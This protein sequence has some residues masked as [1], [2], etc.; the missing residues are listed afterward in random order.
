MSCVQPFFKFFHPCFMG[1]ILI[2]LFLL[3]WVPNTTWA[4]CVSI[5][6][7]MPRCEG[8]P[9]PLKAT[10]LCG[11]K[12]SQTWYTFG[13]GFFSSLSDTET[14]YYP[15]HDERVNGSF[16]VGFK[17]KFTGGAEDSLSVTGKINF[18]PTGDFT[19]FTTGCEP[20][21]TSFD[22]KFWGADSIIWDFGDG[23]IKVG[24]EKIPHTY[25]L[26]RPKPYDVY[27]RLVSIAG[28]DT[29]L[30]K[31][32]FVKVNISPNANFEMSTHQVVYPSSPVVTFQNRSDIKGL[33]RD[34]V[35]FKWYRNGILVGATKMSTISYAFTTGPNGKNEIELKVTSVNG[36]DGTYYD[37]VWVYGA[38]PSTGIT[39]PGAIGRKNSSDAIGVMREQLQKYHE[40]RI[41]VYNILGQKMLQ[42]NDAEA[43]NRLSQLP[44]GNYL[45]QL[46]LLDDEGMN[47]QQRAKILVTE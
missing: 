10:V 37:Y 39:I 16:R 11:Q 12:L 34:S 15:G 6:P 8:I 19:G 47:N 13:D 32:G 18:T 17:V 2:S 41:E 14:I 43:L 40:Y 33:P 25:F 21:F 38:G 26:A 22:G 28:C 30:A 35:T 7:V 24:G 36:C 29:V 3:V 42:L 45:I 20:F 4:G 31:P 1:K 23:I 9:F 27:V 46:W 5:E 44:P